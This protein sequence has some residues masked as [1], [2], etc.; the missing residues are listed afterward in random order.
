MKR[1]HFFLEIN[2]HT[3]QLFVA[4]CV[5]FSRCYDRDSKTSQRLPRISNNFPKPSELCQNLPKMFR[6][7]LSTVS[8]LFKRRQPQ[9]VLISPGWT[10][11]HHHSNCLSGIFLRKSNYIFVINHVIKEQFFWICES[12]M[13]NCP[14][15][16]RLI[17]LVRRRETRA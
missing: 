10:Q 12:G 7:P 4:Q 17:S 8:K 3:C 1:M 16:A 11:S 13:R 14:W 9:L 6:R 15:W 2:N 5:R